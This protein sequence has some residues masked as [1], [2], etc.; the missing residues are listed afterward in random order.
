MF[1]AFFHIVMIVSAFVSGVGLGAIAWQMWRELTRW[2][3]SA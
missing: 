1:E 3:R 2:L